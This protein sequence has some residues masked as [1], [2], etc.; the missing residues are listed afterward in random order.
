VCEKKEGT[1]ADNE[2]GTNHQMPGRTKASNSTILSQTK[3]NCE[4]SVETMIRR[5][6]ASNHAGLNIAAHIFFSMLWWF[7]LVSV[8]ALR[9]ILVNHR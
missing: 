6:G 3:S 5:M 4:C 8:R 2:A 7:L 9:V 1:S